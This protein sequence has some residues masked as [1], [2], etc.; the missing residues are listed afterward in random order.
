MNVLDRHPCTVDRPLL[1]RAW[2]ATG[3]STPQLVPVTTSPDRFVPAQFVDDCAGPQGEN[4]RQALRRDDSS[5]LFQKPVPLGTYSVRS[6]I[7]DRLGF[8]RVR[9]H[10]SNPSYSTMED[11]GSDEKE[12][13]R[14]KVELCDTTRKPWTTPF[15]I[16]FTARL[17]DDKSYLLVEPSPGLRHFLMK[18]VGHASH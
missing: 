1:Y 15:T 13:P 7:G 5:R 3:R 10:P 17:E 8:A 12:L 14:S 6:Q 16:S 9:R 18:V 11:A 2:A 4:D